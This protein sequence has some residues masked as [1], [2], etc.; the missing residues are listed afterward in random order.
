MKQILIM[1]I[2]GATIFAFHLQ[3]EDCKVICDKYESC[4]V[5]HWTKLGKTPTAADI[6]KLQ[7]GC[8]NTCK[9]HTET[10]NSC[11]TKSLSASNTCA[12]LH[13]CVTDAAKRKNKNKGK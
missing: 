9:K 3:A 6:K 13:T 12:A 10:I 8:M 5:D 11:Y 7:Q 4:T 2:L 1:L